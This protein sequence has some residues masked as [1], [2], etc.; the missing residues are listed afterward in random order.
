MFECLYICTDV[1]MYTRIFVHMYI[2][3]HVYM[4]TSYIQT[5]CPPENRWRCQIPWNWRY[6]QLRAS[7]CGHWEL[8]LGPLPEQPMLLTTE[9]SLWHQCSIF[10]WV[11]LDYVC[12]VYFVLIYLCTQNVL[13]TSNFNSKEVFL[14]LI[15][16]FFWLRKPLQLRVTC[17]F[18]I[19]FFLSVCHSVFTMTLADISYFKMG[20]LR[21]LL[22]LI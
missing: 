3:T 8:N 9:P 21:P 1:Y 18:D 17:T 12:L 22:K 4:Y 11:F 20:N 2:C 10:I 19:L 14:G 5:R 13:S 7:W 16:L 6:R 15:L